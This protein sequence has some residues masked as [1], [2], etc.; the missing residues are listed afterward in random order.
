MLYTV[1]CTL[2]VNCG[3]WSLIDSEDFRAPCSTKFI[4]SERFLEGL[5]DSMIYY[6]RGG[7]HRNSEE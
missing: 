1:H 4:V 5:L 2:Y 6:Q 3:Q 7:V